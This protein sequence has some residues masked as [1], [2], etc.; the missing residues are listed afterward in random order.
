MA[1]D[2]NRKIT[3]TTKTIRWKLPATQPETLNLPIE[4]NAHISNKK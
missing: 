1:W 3:K 4:N 2:H